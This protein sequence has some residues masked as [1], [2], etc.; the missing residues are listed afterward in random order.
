MRGGPGDSA[1]RVQGLGVKVYRVLGFKV[2]GI[3]TRV[4]SKARRATNRCQ[5]DG[6]W[7]YFSCS[8]PCQGC[9]SDA[10]A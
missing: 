7:Q 3:G 5:K 9:W 6:I 2:Q 8:D 1:S 4:G 10:S